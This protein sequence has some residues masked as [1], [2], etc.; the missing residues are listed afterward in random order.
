[1]YETRGV[2]GRSFLRGVLREE[3]FEGS[4]SRG[5]LREE[6][7]GGSPSRG[8]FQKVSFERSPSGSIA[9]WR[10]PIIEFP[11]AGRVI[12]NHARYSY[13]PMCFSTGHLENFRFTSVLG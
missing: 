5:V 12:I 10:S 4:P 9:T 11:I 2:F 8:V 13:E 1:M 6:S 7:F 3:S